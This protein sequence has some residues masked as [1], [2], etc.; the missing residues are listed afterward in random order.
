MYGITQKQSRLLIRL[1]HFDT[2]GV[3]TIWSKLPVNTSWDFFHYIN[4]SENEDIYIKCF[5][6]YCI[7]ESGRISVAEAS[8]DAILFQNFTDVTY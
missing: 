7:G 2:V 5:M 4:I 8:C 6:W 3:P 1:V